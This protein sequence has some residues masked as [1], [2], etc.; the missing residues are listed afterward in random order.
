VEHVLHP[1][2]R[3]SQT[4]NGEHI[5]ENRRLAVSW[6]CLLLK[7]V[8]TQQFAR[9]G[10]CTND[11]GVP[12]SSGHWLSG[13]PRLRKLI[14]PGESL[15]DGK[16]RSSTLLSVSSPRAVRSGISTL[17]A[18]A[19][20]FTLCSC[21]WAALPTSCADMQLHAKLLQSGTIVHITMNPTS[22]QGWRIFTVVSFSA[23]AS[24]QSG[25]PESISSGHSG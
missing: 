3:T 17:K 4:R 1:L 7:S 2:L 16:Q 13:H 12:R 20:S 24:G 21:A 5:D 18:S 9:G 23:S 19:H 25:F 11:H 10:S 6:G 22:G 15:Q 8:R 14:D